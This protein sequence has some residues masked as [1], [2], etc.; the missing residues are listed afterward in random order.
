MHAHLGV[1]AL[2][3]LS[4]LSGCVSTRVGPRVG[5]EIPTGSGGINT[6][7]GITAEGW[8]SPSGFVRIDPQVRVLHASRHLVGQRGVIFEYMA[9]SYDLVV[10]SRATFLE[11]PIMLGF[12][13]ADSSRLQ[14]IFA[15]GGSLFMRVHS[16]TTT[17]GTVEVIE[18]SDQ[19]STYEI[20][21][22]RFDNSN[23]D[24]A[25]SVF[26]LAGLTYA[27][28]PTMDVRAEVRATFLSSETPFW[29][30]IA[31]Y[32]VG[33]LYTEFAVPSVSMSIM[34]SAVFHL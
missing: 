8:Y 32:S 29:D 34:L 12:V 21:P 6:V 20:N 27:A 10:Q 31:G 24:I 9:N 13:L 25:G 22:T 11:L 4:F 17:A 19:V 2:M 23:S 30:P 26:A 3:V 28:T 1:L 14:P 16:T 15:F 5:T 18:S 33:S 7:T